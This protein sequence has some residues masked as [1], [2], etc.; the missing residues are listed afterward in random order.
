MNGDRPQSEKQVQAPPSN[1]GGAFFYSYSAPTAEERREIDGIRRQYTA[2]TAA[3]TKLAYVKKLDRRARRAPA[4]AALTLGIVGLLIFGGGL[5]ISM[6]GIFQGA[7]WAGVAVSVTG[8]V[9]MALAKP[10]HSALAARFKRKYGGTI[11][12]LTSE[13]LGE[14]GAEIRTD[15]DGKTL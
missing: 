14:E 8:V 5:A 3:E 6:E 15:Y 7:L 10:L 1:G 9:V 13:L 11:L 2:R 4:A 12:K